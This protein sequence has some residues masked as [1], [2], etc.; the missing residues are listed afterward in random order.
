MNCR[1]A[2]L[3]SSRYWGFS[4]SLIDYDDSGVDGFSSVKSHGAL[5][6]S[7]ILRALANAH[8][9]M[10]LKLLEQSSHNVMDLCEHLNLRQ[11]LVSQHL[12]RLRLDDI[13]GAERQG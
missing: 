8:R 12:A 2:G 13:V 10:I 3:Q 6:A 4:M 7:N 9:L 5:E 1:D 11:S